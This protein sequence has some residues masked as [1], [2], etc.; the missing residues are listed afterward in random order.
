MIQY[1][2]ENYRRVQMKKK[3]LKQNVSILNLKK[4]LNLE[5]DITVA[6]WKD[7][8]RA[9]I[10]DLLEIVGLSGAPDI[11]EMPDADRE[12]M[13]RRY[14]ECVSLMIVDSDVDGLDFSTPELAEESFE[15]ERIPW[16]TFHKAIIVYLARLTEDY[17]VLKNV[18]RRVKEL[19]NSGK[20][21]QKNEESQSE[22]P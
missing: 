19:S 11:S 8:S 5:Q 4:D 3:P 1:H 21:D 20:K 12:K 10:F 13:N 14:F 22:T 7:P 16:G 18:L 2:Y 9:V 6:F 15:D 17:E